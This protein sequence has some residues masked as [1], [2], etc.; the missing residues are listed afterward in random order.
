MTEQRKGEIALRIVK[1]ML[2]EKG[3]RLRPGFNRE[4]ADG[5]KKIGV[6]TEEA[7]EFAVSLY[8]E[9]TEEFITS[10]QKPI[11]ESRSRVNPDGDLHT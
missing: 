9:A 2:R 11:V 10:L 1:H 4:I 7:V 8:R 6:P 3:V 5:A